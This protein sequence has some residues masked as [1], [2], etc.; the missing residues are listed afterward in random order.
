M[1]SRRLYF[2]VVLLFCIK[3]AGDTHLRFRHNDEAMIQC[4]LSLWLS[5]WH[6]IMNARGSFS[7]VIMRREPVTPSLHCSPERA[8]IRLCHVAKEEPVLCL[9]RPITM[10]A[11]FMK[12]SLNSW[13]ISPVQLWSFIEACLTVSLCFV[14]VEHAGPPMSAWPSFGQ[15]RTTIE[16]NA[17][18]S[19]T[20][21]YT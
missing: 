6:M 14:V 1:I 19:P 12:L 2:I 5:I 8:L 11:I 10:K 7:F 17:D 16:R 20:R 3:I 21:W 15:W 13:C 18:N 4:R 9:R